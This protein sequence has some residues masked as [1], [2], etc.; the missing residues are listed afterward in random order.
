MI[1]ITARPR[2]N[3][4]R[5]RGLRA[6][7]AMFIAIAPAPGLCRAQDVSVLRDVTV[8]DGTGRPARPHRNVVIEGG[9]IRSI[10]PASDPIPSGAAT[11]EVAGTTIMPL[12]V[13]AHGH[14]GLLK[15]T[16]TAADHYGEENIRRHL[17]QYEAFGVGAV[18]ALGSDTEAVF[19]LRELSRRGELPGAVLFT[20]GAGFGVK[21][22]LPP[23]AMGMTR[24]NRPET[25]EEARRQVRELAAHKP[26]A[27]KLW[28]DDLF[29]QLP[30]MEPA[31]YAAIIDEAHRRGIRVA[32]HVFY[33]E[34]A[35]KLV[36]LGVEILAHSVRDAEIDDGLLAEMKARRV[37]YIPTLSLDEFAFAYREMPP[38]FHEPF[39]RASLEPGVFE[40]VSSSGYKEAVRADFKTPREMAALAVAQKNLKKVHD[41]GILVALGSDS[42]ATP[43]RPIGFAEHMELQLM[44]QAGLTSLEAIAVATRNGARLLGI[45]GGAGSLEPGKNANFIVLE[46]DP[47]DEIRNTEAIRSV[48]TLGRKVNDGPLPARGRE[49]APPVR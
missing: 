1:R 31:I 15:G 13:N 14:P 7:L 42:G 28:V 47:S 9:V 16:T 33:L 45:D 38:W 6:G 30:K 34:D 36:G 23:V 26:D 27:V 17:L 49:V 22:A 48:W 12:I 10:G 18:L 39:F 37:A 4:L 25:P 19:P 2:R 3:L 41:A 24:V 35:R 46:K 29:G 40:M 44:V 21:G 32:A 43:I 5:V 8:I 11:V 20:A